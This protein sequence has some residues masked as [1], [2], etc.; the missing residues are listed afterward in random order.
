MF[1]KYMKGEL[2]EMQERDQKML[3]EEGGLWDHFAGED[4]LLSFE[5]AEKMRHTAMKMMEK[6]MDMK[7]PEYPEDFVKKA[8]KAFDDLNPETSGVSKDDDRLAKKIFEA[9]RHKW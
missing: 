1:L 2:K 8:Y 5:E 7:L 4:G 6:H 9:I 3:Y